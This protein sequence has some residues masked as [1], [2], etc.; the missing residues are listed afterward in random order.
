MFSTICHEHRFVDIVGNEQ[1]DQPSL[2]QIR[3]AC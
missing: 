3:K 1:D 2:V